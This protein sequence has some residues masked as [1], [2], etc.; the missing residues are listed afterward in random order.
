MQLVFV[1]S[2]RIAHLFYARQPC[3][4]KEFFE[5]TK[6]LGSIRPIFGLKF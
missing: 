6:G 1:V 2:K 5:N 3:S 4:S